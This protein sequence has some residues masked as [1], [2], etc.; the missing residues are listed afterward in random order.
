MNQAMVELFQAHDGMILTMYLNI[1]VSFLL[2]TVLPRMDSGV[3]GILTK[4]K[5]RSADR[6]C[7]QDKG[8]ITGL[9][10]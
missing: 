7:K 5:I 9:P 6:F 3:P 10:P 8:G 2:L 4:K 1:G